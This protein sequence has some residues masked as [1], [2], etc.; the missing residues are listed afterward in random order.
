MTQTP[1]VRPSRLLPVYLPGLRTRLFYV[2]SLRLA[3]L[4]LNE[5]VWVKPC[6]HALL[7]TVKGL[8]RPF[9]NLPQALTSVPMVGLLVEIEN[10]IPV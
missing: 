4:G 2:G 9:A 10:G 6:V 5:M 3:L 7:F 8:V 1:S